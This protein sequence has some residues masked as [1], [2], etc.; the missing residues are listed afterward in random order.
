[1][2]KQ[3]HGEDGRWVHEPKSAAESQNESGS[4]EGAVP[5]LSLPRDSQVRDLHLHPFDLPGEA[6]LRKRKIVRDIKSSHARARSYKAYPIVI[7]AVQ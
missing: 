1:V 7:A 2:K 3:I 4:S 5:I 6:H